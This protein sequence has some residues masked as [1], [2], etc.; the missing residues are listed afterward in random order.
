ML[1]SRMATRPLTWFGPTPDENV[2]Q[3]AH[4]CMNV[5]PVHGMALMADQH[6]GYSSMP[7]GGVVA[8]KGAISPSG[9]G[10]DIACGVKAVR[11]QYHAD[12]FDKRSLSV[13]LDEMESKIAF[14][15]G[16][17]AQERNDHKVME[18]KLW[19]TLAFE[20]RGLKEMAASQLGSVGGGNHY[21]DILVDEADG[22]VWVAAHFGSRGFGNKVG[23]YFGKLL[24]AKD[25]P[26]APPSI[27]M[28]DD[29]LFAEYVDAMD[30]AGEYAYAG[31]DI[32]IAQVLRMLGAR[33]V[34]TVH[35]HHNFAWGEE[36]DGEQLIVVRKGATPAQP[37]QRGFVGGSM[38][39][40][41]AI[42]E[43]TDS[44]HGALTF[45][46]TVHGAGRVH[47]R[48][49]AKGKVNRRTREVTRAGN[50]TLD[51]MQAAVAE[52]GTQVRGGDV[53]ESPMVYRKLEG[54]LDAMG[55]TITVRNRLRP[56]GVV[57]APRGVR[58]DDG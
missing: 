53:D 54:V 10:V 18:S 26:D 16:V 8:Y 44:P 45:R 21:V 48:G 31:R 4:T 55:G 51:D 37:G 58:S 22:A 34:E 6:Y 13:L 9:V 41:A 52:F 36:H 57:M 30:L 46:S 25:A 15:M 12:I 24:G 28:A 49:W 2:L 38:G 20:L 43:G 40:I 1:A 32:V 42:V 17:G 56:I 47:S 50:V 14:G 29:P 7:V 33:A 3:Q 39:D 35:N 19:R 27:I 11:T 23:R 5:G